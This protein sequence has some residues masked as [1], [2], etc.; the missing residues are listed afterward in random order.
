MGGVRIAALLLKQHDPVLTQGYLRRL[1]YIGDTN[2]DGV[3]HPEEL[4]SLLKRPCRPA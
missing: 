1:F 2:R 4:K 3:L